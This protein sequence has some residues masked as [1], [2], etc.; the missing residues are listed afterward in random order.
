MDIKEFR[1]QWKNDDGSPK[2]EPHMD[3]CRVCDRQRM[4]TYIDDHPEDVGASKEED[5][6]DAPIM[7]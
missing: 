1:L 3:L 6:N 5:N 4:L 7:V 2:K